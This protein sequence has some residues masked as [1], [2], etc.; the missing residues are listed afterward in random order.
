MKKVF[1][2]VAVVAIALSAS[3]FTNG[4]VASSKTYAGAQWFEYNLDPTDA[5]FAVDKLVQTN[6]TPTGITSST[7]RPCPLASDF[8][9]IYAETVSGQPD[10]SSG[11]PIVA[12]LT[13]YTNGSGDQLLIDEKN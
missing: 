11:Q 8:C 7:T 3:A 10:L 12:S 4:N 5:N 9:S 6:Y 13:S 2:G 1:F